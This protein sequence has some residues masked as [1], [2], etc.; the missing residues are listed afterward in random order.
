MNNE[1]E[2]VKIDF[3]NGLFGFE[4]YTKFTL[5]EA[6]YKPFYWLQS[7]QDK[8]LSF[9]VVDPFIFFDD[10]ELDID[11][12]SLKS[13]EVKTPADVV[14]LTIITIPGNNG[15]ITANLQGPLVINKTNN[16]GM[17]FVLSDPKWTPKHEL[18]AKQTKD[19]DKC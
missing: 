5:I 9:L 3:P 13:I 17:Q 7:E 15:K 8:T 6:E 11:D 12:N 16:L 1:L 19:G 2:T 10:Y 18:V 14:V 4:G